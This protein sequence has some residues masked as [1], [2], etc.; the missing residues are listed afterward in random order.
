MAIITFFILRSRKKKA[1]VKEEIV[2]KQVPIKKAPEKKRDIKENV[3]PAPREAVDC[4]NPLFASEPPVTQ[5]P[6]IEVSG[7]SGI[8]AEIESFADLRDKGIITEEEFQKK[9][10][11]LLES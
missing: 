2:A 6:N 9:K 10:K 7:L 11:E 5:E 3:S 4:E 1:K 8:A